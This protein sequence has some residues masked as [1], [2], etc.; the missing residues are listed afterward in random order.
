MNTKNGDNMI[1]YYKKS[2]KV[3]KDYIVQNPQATKE[4]WDEYA[5]NNNLFSSQTLMFHFFHEDLVKYLNKNK[6]EKFEYLKNMFLVIPVKYRKIK[7]FKTLIKIS[8]SNKERI[9]ERN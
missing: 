5:Q 1:N 4:E 8:N 6:K 7:I 2:V 9:K 3:F